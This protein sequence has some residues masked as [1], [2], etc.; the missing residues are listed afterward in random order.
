[1]FGQKG[2]EDIFPANKSITLVYKYTV[3][4]PIQETKVFILSLVLSIILRFLRALLITLIL[5]ERWEMH[6]L[7][8][9]HLK[10]AHV[11]I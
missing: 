9:E 6:V 8:D 10:L 7:F 1:M 4:E 2:P 11:N 5:D 3:Q